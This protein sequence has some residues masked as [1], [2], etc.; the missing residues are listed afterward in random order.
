MQ[1]SSP[2]PPYLNEYKD[3]LSNILCP[4]E[5][6]QIV[7]DNPILPVVNPPRRI[8]NSFQQGGS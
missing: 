2:L 7:I 5:K 4:P 1:I 6:Q 8:P 3:L